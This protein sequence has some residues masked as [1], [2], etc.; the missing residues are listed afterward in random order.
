MYRNADVYLFTSHREA[1][2]LPVVEAMANKC[3]VIGRRIGALAELG[4]SKNSMLVADNK[5]MYQSLLK[6]YNN[7]QLLRE[8]QNNGYES[9]QYLSWNNSCEKFLKYLRK[10]EG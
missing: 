1:W 2:G 4:T 5:E 10:I 3:A 8:I 7:R 6:L 9:V